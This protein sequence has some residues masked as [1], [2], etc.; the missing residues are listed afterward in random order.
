LS[1]IKIL[2]H[3]L[4]AMVSIDSVSKSFSN[5]CVAAPVLSE[6]SFVIEAGQALAL[7][8]ANGAGKSTVI[9]I[10]ATLSRPDSGCAT[11]AGFDTVKEAPQVRA[12]IG[13][14]LQNVSIYPAGKVRQV[15][16]HHAR[17][18]GLCRDAAVRRGNEIIEL[19]GLTSV[20]D[21]R[22]R[23]L[24]GGTRR[25]LDLG[26]ALVHRAPVLLLDEPTNGLDS[27]SRR[28]FWCELGRLRDKGTCILFTSQSLE[29]AK[30]LADQTIVLAN[31]VASRV[32]TSAAKVRES[33]RRSVL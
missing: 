24:S 12:R 32:S 31:G 15:V 2:K 16:Q 28:E 14:A 20:A 27:F 11:I 30:L 4:M 5:R 18:Y 22:V 29:E 13:V 26:L 6:L 3:E 9:R 33:Q 1:Y 8:G 21:M 19:A 23:H 7:L 17:L 10:L 25:R